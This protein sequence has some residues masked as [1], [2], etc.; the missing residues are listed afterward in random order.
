[1]K[2]KTNKKEIFPVILEPLSLN[3]KTARLE[4]VTESMSELSA[5]FSWCCEGYTPN[6]NLAR[7]EDCIW[8]R[9]SGC[10]YYFAIVE[11]DT[12]N[13]VG[14]IAIDE[15]YDVEQSGNIMYWVRSDYKGRGYAPLAVLELARFGFRELPL[16]ELKIKVA[17][18]N[19]PSIRVAEKVGAKFE[20]LIPDY[21]QSNGQISDIY[22]YSIGEKK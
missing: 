19:Q 9:Q 11:A 5:I 12:R 10:E 20:M 1:M 13:F 22:C 16:V 18:D 8:Y 21:E 6:S 2:P 3:H 7:I 17:T 4:A 14:E 15:I